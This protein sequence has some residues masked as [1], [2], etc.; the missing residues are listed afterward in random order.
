MQENKKLNPIPEQEKFT[1]YDSWERFGITKHWGVINAT[2]RLIELCNITPDQYVLDVG[3]GTGYTACLLAKDYQAEVV[4]ADLRSKVLEE[5]K[6]RIA[7]ENVGGRG[8]NNSG[9]CV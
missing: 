2:R 6:K 3:C 8:G 5:A 9:R 1:I 7:K 4:A